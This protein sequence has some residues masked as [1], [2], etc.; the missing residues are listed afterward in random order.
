MA[1]SGP[2]KIRL[3]HDF[4]GVHD[5]L[6]STGDPSSGGAAA[7]GDFY[8][9]GEGYEDND[10]G[11]AGKDALSGVVT[12]TSANSDG[13]TTFIGT[14]IAFDVA[15]MAP[16]VMETRVQFADLD[17][18]ELFFGLTSVLSVDEQ[19]EDI[20]IH[21]AA[22]TVA[23]PADL[24]GFYLSSEK[25]DDEAWH[26]I[27]NGGTTSA[28]TTTTSVCLGGTGDATSVGATAGE[29]QVLRLEVAPNGTARWYV[30]GVLYQ[31]VE[32]AASTTTNMAVCLAVGANTTEFAIVDCDY[33]LVEANRDWTV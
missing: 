8:A 22:G 28:S 7:L 9:G 30:D 15:L 2:G 23:M 33:I 3:F 12:L 29:W 24:V 20:V 13:D 19:L 1:Q 31:T 26:G 18:K 6:A 25:T 27:H 10:A 14:H 5:V 32:G 16:I 4:F 11:V 21:A 17:D